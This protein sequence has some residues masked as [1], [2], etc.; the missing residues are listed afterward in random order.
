MTS[1][2]RV[3]SVPVNSF[4][5]PAQHCSGYLLLGELLPCT[6]GGNKRALELPVL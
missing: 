4:I 3:G 5:C 2:S 1:C 6:R